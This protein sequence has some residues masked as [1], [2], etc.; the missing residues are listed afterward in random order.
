MRRLF[1]TQEENE[2]FTVQERKYIDLREDQKVRRF[3]K[4]CSHKVI[5]TQTIA[6]ETTVYTFKLASPGPNLA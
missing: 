2:S 5:Q 4:D 6:R 1:E 3:I